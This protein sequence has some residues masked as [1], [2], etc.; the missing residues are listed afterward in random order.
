MELLS[1]LNELKQMKWIDLSHEFGENTPRWPG[2]ESLRKQNNASN[3]RTIR[4]WK[5]N[6]V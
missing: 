4:K 3:S 2:F 1:L 6:I 5:N